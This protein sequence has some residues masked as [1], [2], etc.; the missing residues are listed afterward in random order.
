MFSSIKS[1][2]LTVLLLL[3]AV[4]FNAH[5]ESERYEFAESSRSIMRAGPGQSL[6]MPISVIY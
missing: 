2:S 5:A 4:F 3:F 1:V 6:S